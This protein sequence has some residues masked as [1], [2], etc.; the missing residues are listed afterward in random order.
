MGANPKREWVESHF[1]PYQQR[2]IFDESTV[3]L[4]NKARQ[5]G[6]S[7]GTAGRIIERGHYRRRP[8]IFISAS[9]D[10]A[11]ELLRTVRIH[12]EILAALGNRA[13]NRYAVD[14]SERLEWRTGGSVV[15]LSSNAR[16]GRSFHGDVYFDEFAFHENPAKLWSA[17]A[18]MASR[19]D[20]QLRIIST[21]NG[22]QGLF[23][24]WADE[25]TPAGWS[26][27]RVTVDDAE[28]MGLRVDRA[29][30]L[31][32]VGGDPRMFGEAYLCQFL[33]ANLQ[34]IPTAF[35]SL[36]R[37]WTG[38]LPDLANAVW[39]AGLD[40][41]RT[42]DVTALAVVAVLGGV[43]WVVAVLTCPRTAFKAQ[44]AMIRQA[45]AVFRWETLHVDET[46]LGKQL[47]EELVEEFGEDEAIPVQFTE[48]AKA[49]LVTRALRWHRDGRVRYPRGEAGKA[50]HK[51]AISLRRVVTDKNNVTYQFPRTADGHGDE[52]TALMLALRGAGEPPV[53]RGMGQ[54]PL[55]R[56]A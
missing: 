52:F 42:R 37:D 47:A 19:G 51:Q 8:Q 15:A 16:T 31:Q 13:A 21:P 25:K 49:D 12:C 18:P 33:D 39:Y 14:N 26:V 41:G 55:F 24:E 29:K 17:A 38:A 6:F 34:F 32:L 1:L 3:A 36:A 23:H 46:G 28:A 48:Q 9:Q 5:I 40:V 54:G 11:D 43:A 20:W 53:V 22:A 35:A 56:V 30:L 7:D 27:H 4:A 10:L 50:L 45:R 2:W 44:K